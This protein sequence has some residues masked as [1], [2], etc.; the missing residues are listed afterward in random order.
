V[1]HKHFTN[2]TKN[3]TTHNQTQFFCKIL[4]TV[5]HGC[6]TP[7]ESLFPS[8]S[9]SNPQTHLSLSLLQ[10]HVSLTSK[11]IYHRETWIYGFV[12][13]D[14]QLL[15]VDMYLSVDFGDDVDVF[16]DVDEVFDKFIGERTVR[17]KVFKLN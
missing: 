16:E 1:P 4:F 8:S 14:G 12:K 15:L 2:K 17:F 7:T 10:N 11:L 5:S 9:L 6:P 13:S 3:S